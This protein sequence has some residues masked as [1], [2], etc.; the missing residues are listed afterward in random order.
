[1][2]FQLPPASG[3]PELNL[4]ASRSTI[5]TGVELSPPEIVLQTTAR[6][7]TT[8]TSQEDLTVNQD[9]G[10]RVS[11]P[12]PEIEG[13]RSVISAGLNFKTYNVQS[14]KSLNYEFIEILHH[15]PGDAGYQQIGYLSSPFPTSAMNIQYVPISFRWDAS[16]V[17]SLGSFSFGFN[18][19]PNI[20]ASGGS[21][22][23]QSITGSTKSSANWQVLGASAGRDQLLY[24]DWRL[25]VRADGQWSS[26]P[27]ISNEQFGDGGV[28]GVRGY[29]EGEVFGDTGWRVTSE[30][31]TPVRTVGLING[32]QML[33]IRGSLFMDYAETYLLDP[34]GRDSRTPLWGTGC[35]VAANIGSR[36]EARLV[37]GWPLL[38]S[39]TSEAGQLRISFALN[40]QF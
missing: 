16:R 36:G 34:L 19:N 15:T 12:L 35:G 22:N 37:F 32:T 30:L 26:Q 10:F 31:K 25:A 20:W 11:Q 38:N 9:L 40:A 8:Q 3:A 29:R 1:R 28:N 13:L 4:Y 39:P 18:Y 6:T 33:T 5:D 23:V 21:T 14:E 17:D 24:R 7:I 2:R 27:L